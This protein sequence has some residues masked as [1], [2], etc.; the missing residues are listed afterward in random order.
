MKPSK[1]CNRHLKFR[2]YWM[3]NDRQKI[4]LRILLTVGFLIGVSAHADV[5]VFLGLASNDR[6]EVLI[7]TF[8]IKKIQVGLGALSLYKGN[9]DGKISPQLKNAIGEY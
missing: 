4:A 2:E 5:L 7:D 6:G 8:S 3:I 1:G 9:V